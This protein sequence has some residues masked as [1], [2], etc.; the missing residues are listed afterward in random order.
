[1]KELGVQER[2]TS[3]REIQERK[4]EVEERF[5]RNRNECK[6]DLGEKEIECVLTTTTDQTTTCSKH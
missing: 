4:S 1:M 2:V 5:R 6:K 3:E